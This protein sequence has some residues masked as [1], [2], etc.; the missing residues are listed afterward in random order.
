MHMKLFFKKVDY[1]V[2]AICSNMWKT[3]FYSVLLILAIWPLCHGRQVYHVTPNE[4]TNCHNATVSC[5]ILEYYAKELH[6]DPFYFQQQTVL[7]FHPGIHTLEGNIS[8]IFIA[9]QEVVL[10]GSDETSSSGSAPFESTEILCTSE[11]AAGFILLLVNNLVIKNLTFTS[12][13]LVYGNASAAIHIGFVTN[14]TIS[15]SRTKQYRI[16]SCSCPW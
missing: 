12:C 11:P 13:W 6:S 9:M 15:H 1:N 2:G 10:L 14:L 5:H 8:I 7:Y 4:E 3:T 16:W